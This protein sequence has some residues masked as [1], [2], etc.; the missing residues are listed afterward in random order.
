MRNHHLSEKK[1]GTVDPRKTHERSRFT[2]WP[3]KQSATQN[4]YDQRAPSQSQFKKNKVDRKFIN[5]NRMVH[6]QG[7]H[8]GINGII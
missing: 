7:Q 2:Q 5:E 8:N 4:F 1:L 3:K 6:H